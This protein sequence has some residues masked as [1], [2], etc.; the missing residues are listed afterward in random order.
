MRVWWTAPDDTGAGVGNVYP[1]LKYQVVLQQTAIAA[2]PLA[3]TSLVKL[4]DASVNETEF[5][6]L[7]KGVQY[8]AFVRALNDAGQ[9]PGDE[10][11]GPWGIGSASCVDGSERQD[12]CAG[13]GVHAVH[14][15]EKVSDLQL[16]PIGDGLL[17]AVW[18]APSDTGNG[19]STYPLVRY[20]LHLQATA[21]LIM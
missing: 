18:W 6:M 14:R 4:L 20:D 12:V 17:T 21:N 16:L 7:Q 8:F 15:P 2:N 9:Y 19:L 1:L 10:G 5:S 13:N 3:A 11:Y